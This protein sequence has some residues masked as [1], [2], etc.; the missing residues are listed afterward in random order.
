[1]ENNCPYHISDT[2]F[3]DDNAVLN[4]LHLLETGKTEFIMAI[5][6]RKYLFKATIHRLNDGKYQ[7]DFGIPASVISEIDSDDFFSKPTVLIIPSSPN[8]KH[9]GL[10][11]IIRQDDVESVTMSIHS[12]NEIYNASVVLKAFRADCDDSIWTKSKQTAIFRFNPSEFNPFHKGVIY[13]MTTNVNQ[14]SLNKN[15]LKIDIN[16]NSYLFYYETIDKELGFFFVKSPNLVN[17]DELYN[18]SDAIRS[19]YALLTGYYIAESAFYFSMK[20][21]N[22]RSLTFRYNCIDKT[23]ISKRPILDYRHYQNLSDEEILLSSSHFN[24][25]VSILYKEISLRRACVMI[26]QAGSLDNVSKGCLASVSLETVTSY[27]ASKQPSKIG[28]L[29]EDKSIESQLEYELNKAIKKVKNKIDAKTWQTLKSKIGKLNEQTNAKKLS[30]PFSEL[31]IKLSEDEATCLDCRN[32]YLHG[33]LPKNS[34]GIFK[35]LTQNEKL[36]LIANRL[37]MLSAIL[38][39]KKAGYDGRVIDWGITE[40]IY[41]RSIASGQGQKKLSFQHRFVSSP[42]E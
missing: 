30:N 35:N 4:F 40:I 15:A 13:D 36:L 6:D 3:A 2:L 10:S 12:D 17:F 33:S 27:F 21:H 20:P 22:K 24:R 19:A 18:V 38:L 14:K 16:K 28:K 32:Y 23:I 25:L 31:G 37:C 5:Y 42:E 39:L 9:E 41:K 8:S 7:L 34:N 29:I 1:M 26:T 11:I